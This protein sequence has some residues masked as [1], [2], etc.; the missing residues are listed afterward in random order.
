MQTFLGLA[1]ALGAATFG[2]VT[3]GQ[4]A[5]C[6]IARQYLTQASVI[7]AGFSIFA[8]TAVKGSY[9]GYVMFVWIYGVFLG[10]YAYSVKMYIYEKVSRLVCDL[11]DP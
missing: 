3:V 10:G 8:L 5:E 6:R 11:C 4:S 2:I 7:A 9:S 1:W